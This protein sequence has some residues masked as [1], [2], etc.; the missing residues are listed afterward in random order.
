MRW[1]QLPR[2]DED[3]EDRTGDTGPS[4]PSGFPSSFPIG[5]GHLGIGGMLILGLI[6]YALGIDPRMLIGG[7][8][9]LL[10]NNQ[11]TQQRAPNTAPRPTGQLTSADAPFV[12]SVLRSTAVTWQMIF[13]KNG[14]TYTRPRLVMFSGSTNSGCGTAQS[15][16]GPFYCPNDRLIYLDTSFF[17]DLEVRFRGCAGKACEFARA[18]VIAHEVGHHVQNLFDILPKAQAQQR[19]SSD[20]AAANRIQVRVELQADC[21]A[22]VWAYHANEKWSSLLEPGDIEA[23]LKTAAAIGDDMLQRQAGGRV[24]PDSFTHGTSEQRSRWFNIGFKQGSVA[25]CN[26]F[27]ASNV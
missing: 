13:E 16:M 10:G 22:G 25:A 2:G 5:G 8:D 18:Y 4:G 14:Q 7:A 6:G 9:I 26:T 20:R 19:A 23:A 11:Q 21:Y 15:Q 1:D 24:V 27:A 3:V 17:K 12:S